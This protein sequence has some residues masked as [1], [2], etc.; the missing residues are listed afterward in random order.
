LSNGV[1][2]VGAEILEETDAPSLP[3]LLLDLVETAHFQ[4]RAAHRFVARQAIRDMTVHESF[5]V[6]PELIVQ[7]LFDGA[8]PNERPK[9]VS[10]IGEHRC[11]RLHAF[12]ALRDD[13]AQLAP[14]TGLGGDPSDDSPPCTS[15]RG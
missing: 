7:V 13:I 12:K 3:V 10:E 2:E 9:P 14:S 4:P 6:K 1:L 8:A 5:Q 15:T 11:L